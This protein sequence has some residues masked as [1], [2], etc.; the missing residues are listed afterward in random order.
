MN[1]VKGSKYINFENTFLINFFL[2]KHFFNYDITSYVSSKIFFKSYF[3]KDKF[4]K[5]FNFGQDIE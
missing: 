4:G 2:L 5:H 1:D 3:L